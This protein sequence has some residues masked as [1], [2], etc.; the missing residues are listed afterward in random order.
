MHP[1]IVSARQLLT[2]SLARYTVRL[3]VDVRSA[4]G[5]E[6]HHV[7]SVYRPGGDPCMHFGAEWSASDPAHKETPIFGV[8]ID[9]THSSY[10][11]H[12]ECQEIPLFLLL[13]IDRAKGE[14]R[15][16]D[17]L[18]SDGEAWALIEVVNQVQKANDRPGSVRFIK[19]YIE[20]L[21]R[22]GERLRVESNACCDY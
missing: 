20:A 6:Y 15:L 10:G 3:F 9:D 1:K 19:Q 11:E 4:G 22:Y 13:A 21:H 14:L 12:P 7:L 2:F 18:A 8:Y 5:T 16:P 17:D